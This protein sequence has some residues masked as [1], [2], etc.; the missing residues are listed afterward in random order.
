MSRVIPL[1]EGAGPS[2][3]HSH[4]IE[5]DAQATGGYSFAL[6]CVRGGER[7]A[8]GLP[9]RIIDDEELDTAIEDAKRAAARQVGGSSHPDGPA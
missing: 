5:Y 7:A 4:R 6:T 3:E 8:F 1:P 9:R 2:G